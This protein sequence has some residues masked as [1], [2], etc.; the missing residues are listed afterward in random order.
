MTLK[1]KCIEKI[2]RTSNRIRDSIPYV[3]ENGKYNDYSDEEHIDWWTNSFWAGIM[4]LMYDETKDEKYMNFAISIEKKLQSVLYEF[5][6]LSH[7]VGFMW[8]HTSVENYKHTGD[9]TALTDSLLAASV[10]A[11]RFCYD[12]NIIRAW[13]GEHNKGVAIIDCVMNLPLLFW[14]DEQMKDD[15]YSKIAKIHL[16]TVKKHF[17]RDNGSSEHIVRFNTDTGA[18]EEKYGGQGCYEGSSWTRGQGWAIYGFIQNYQYTHD[19]SDLETSI[20]AANYFIENAKKTDYKIKCDF[21]QPEEDELYDSS[22]AAVASC[23]MIE[24]YKETGI[25]KYLDAAKKILNSCDKYFCAWENIEDE[26]LL[27]YGCVMYSEHKQTS[28]IYGDFYF[29]KAVCEMDRIMQEEKSR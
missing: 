24:L 11:S 21:C 19:K 28:L 4:W 13:N 26:A 27:N 9:K 12:A 6:R 8:L 2:T 25:N 7:D 3:T 22:A 1:E 15:K 14:A 18:V 23:G 5:V 29:F 10:L 20:N 17:I 16:N